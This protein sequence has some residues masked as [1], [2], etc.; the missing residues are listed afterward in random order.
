MNSWNGLVDGTDVQTLVSHL[1]SARSEYRLVLFVESREALCQTA[2]LISTVS[3]DAEE[4]FARQVRRGD[5]SVGRIDLPMEADQVF[6]T[7]GGVCVNLHRVP[8]DTRCEVLA[9]SPMFV[10]YAPDLDLTPDR[11]RETMAQW[12]R[13]EGLGK[14]PAPRGSRLRI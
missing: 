3:P 10:A 2:E 5:I 14:A 11:E 13:Q 6:R 8:A 12:V 4:A 9:V 1:R 7:L